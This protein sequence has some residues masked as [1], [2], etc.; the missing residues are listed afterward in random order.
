M[1]GHVCG[2]RLL[3]FDQAEVYQGLLRTLVRVAN[4][5][6]AGDELIA[7]QTLF[8]VKLIGG[9]ARQISSG[10]NELRAAVRAAKIA[11]KVPCV[12]LTP[13]WRSPNHKGNGVH[14]RCRLG[15]ITAKRFVTR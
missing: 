15:L 12:I 5:L 2:S 3:G 14:R 6:R 4:Q 9:E 8:V 7:D 1:L 11:G 10:V 13:F